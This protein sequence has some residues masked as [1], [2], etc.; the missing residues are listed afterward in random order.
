MNLITSPLLF[1]YTSSKPTLLK[2]DWSTGGTGYILI[3]PDNSPESLAAIVHLESTG[4][5]LFDC[6]RSGTRL[7]PIIFNFRTNLYHKKDYHSFVGEIACGRWDIL[8]LRKYLWGTLFYWLCDCN[9]IK[10]IFE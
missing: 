9:A 5:S 10:E 3:Q 6:K 1:R 8:Q 7:M 2:T 4:E